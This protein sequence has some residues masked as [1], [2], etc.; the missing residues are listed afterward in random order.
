[1]ALLL[2]VRLLFAPQTSKGPLHAEDE[3]AP[4]EASDFAEQLPRIP[5]KS[6]ADSLQ[7]FQ[8]QPGFRVEL[9][10]NE[11]R[12]ASPVGLDFD[13]DGRL[14]VTEFVE[15]NQEK[16]EVDH[17]RGRIRLLE[18]TEGNGLYDK[19]T[20]FLD[21][22]DTPTAV[23]CYD[24][25]IYIGSVPDLIYAKDTDGD[26]RADIRRTVL[27]GFARDRGGEAIMNSF[28]WSFDNRI[29]I[30]TSTS[31]GDVRRAD[32]PDARPVSV[33]G[34][35]LLLNPRTEEFELISG[36][37]QFGL[38]I[39]DWGRIFVNTNN[40]P[41]FTIMYD[42]RYLARNPYLEVPPAMAQIAA[43]GYTAPVF[44]IS[45]PEPWRVV[46]THLRANS[47]EGE[48]PHPTE[49]DRPFGYFTG[50]SG[51]TIYRGDA[52]PEEYRG[53]IFVGEVANNLVFHAS[54]E[55]DGVR[56]KAE[57]AEADHDF[58]A[59]ADVWSRPVQFANGPDGALYVVDMYRHLIQAAA[60]IPPAILKHL[61]VSGGFD[62]GR[63]YRIVPEHFQRPTQ[64][65]L[66]RATTA[67]LVALLEHPNGWHRDSASRLLFQRQDPGA[68]KP[69]Q[70]LAI[71]STSPLGRMHALYA[72]SGMN[73][74]EAKVVLSALGVEH[75]GV[76]QHALRLAEQFSQDE[77]IAQRCVSMTADP[78]PRVRYQLAF[79]L[80]AFPGEAATQALVALAVR[81]GE[82]VWCRMAILSS[83][84][85]RTPEVFRQLMSQAD[86]VATDSGREFAGQL[87]ALIG[88]E[89]RP[90]DLQSFAEFISGLGENDSRLKQELIARLLARLPSSAV[91]QDSDNTD[92]FAQLLDNCLAES[93]AIAGDE[94]REVNERLAAMEHLRLLPFDVARDVA[95][96][97][98]NFRQPQQIQTAAIQLLSRFDHDSIP[99][100]LTEAWPILSPQLRLAAIDTLCSRSPWIVA[101][102][103]AIEHELIPVKEVDAAHVQLLRT[104]GDEQI[105]T[106]AVKIFAGSL[107]NSR[108]SVV[109]MYKQA[110]EETGSV[111][112]GKAA[113]KKFCASCHQL[114]QVGTQIG[115]DLNAM[116]GQNKQ[117]ILLNIL[118]PNREVKPQ[119]QAY[120]VVV[121]DGRTVNGMIASESAND[122]TVRKADGSVESVLRINID[123]LRS[124]GLSFM[125]EGLEKQIEVSAMTDL[126]EYLSSKR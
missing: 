7:A 95:V 88:S 20:I 4:A 70:E 27:T 15:Y 121:D 14:Y 59:S 33:R 111:A 73:R 78:D 38:G 106:R 10:A 34:Q 35:L 55:A 60:F 116:R 17:G 22:V 98:L 119:F 53:D 104:H 12:L 19:S 45:P 91:V 76:R 99:Q 56:L 26:G 87:A 118:D 122:V 31:G 75:P 123:E 52:F 9:A 101:A 42:S 107:S 50:V 58:L 120:A 100:I 124:T 11:P 39:D 108:Q 85:G 77:A 1:M 63:L 23:C 8:V 117:T 51:I 36:G 90:D 86:F 112:R 28:H 5:P 68:F 103:D 32:Q 65:R 126:L 54:V 89:H 97:L 72:L 49:G 16:G 113:F 92:T 64:P 67:E 94:S 71:H 62:Q 6:P 13:E 40:Q 29:Y 66:S 125:P 81:D 109:D 102:L 18:D 105:R 96:P 114:D 74:L 25:G 24:G 43:G 44:R 47:L 115:A 3:T 93:K 61:D 48:T 83:V 21:N 69:L 80:G 84:H 2:S 79:S 82:E 57:R 41:A 37:G 46:R 30:Q 110:A